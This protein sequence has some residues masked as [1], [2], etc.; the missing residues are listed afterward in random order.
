[1]NRGASMYLAGGAL[2]VFIFP[3]KVVD[4]R[5]HTRF[6]IACT[7][8]QGTTHVRVSGAFQ[9]SALREFR[10]IYEGTTPAFSSS[11]NKP[12]MARGTLFVD[13]KVT[14]MLER[15][16]DYH[17]SNPKSFRIRPRVFVFASKV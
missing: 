11:F 9:F 14:R 2:R 7:T 13:D 5:S 3:R 4:E 8:Y 6:S 15:L 1:M 12:S 17:E 10:T 16:S